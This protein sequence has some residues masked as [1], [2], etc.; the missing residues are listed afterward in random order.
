MLHS[1]CG[2]GDNDG[3][4]DSVNT[5]AADIISTLRRWQDSGGVWRVLDRRGG[6]ATIGLF[7]CTGGS[8]VDRLLCADPAIWDFLDQRPG[9]ED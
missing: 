8:E 2:A 6:T 7:E 1:Y 3:M 4:P 9:S 5:S